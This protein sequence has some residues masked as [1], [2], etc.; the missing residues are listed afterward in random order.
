VCVCEKPVARAARRD[1][2]VCPHSRARR[3]QRRQQQ[4]YR[5]TVCSAQCSRCH[6]ARVPRRQ[7]Q[8][9]RRRRRLRRRRRAASLGVAVLH[10]G[11][12][13]AAGGGA[14]PAA[15]PGH[16][17]P[18]PGPLQAHPRRPRVVGRLL[19]AGPQPRA[20]GHPGAAPSHH[21]VGQPINPLW[22]MSVPRLCFVPL[23]FGWNLYVCL[24]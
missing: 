12:A 2:C 8:Q 18:P 17:A 9:Q 10:L 23:L 7:P 3:R 5:P 1:R 19:G 6:G 11:A 22:I 20:N 15:T 14:A 4:R 24:C 21:Q 13:G 16:R